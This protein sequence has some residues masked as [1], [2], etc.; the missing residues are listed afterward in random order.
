MPWGLTPRHE[1]EA[2]LIGLICPPSPRRNPGSGSSA[3]CSPAAVA[4]P[5]RPA[6]R[7]P[8]TH[9]PRSFSKTRTTQTTLTALCPRDQ[10]DATTTRPVVGPLR[11][12]CAGRRSGLR[13]EALPSARR[14]AAVPEGTD[15]L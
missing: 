1:D 2:R 14:R 6:L 10:Q 11:P 3:A 13:E 4:R 5:S 15:L 9:L 7:R 8:E 12:Q